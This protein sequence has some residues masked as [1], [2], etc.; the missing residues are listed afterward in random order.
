MSYELFHSDQ[1]S[2]LI[3]DEEKMISKIYGQFYLKQKTGIFCHINQLDL[4]SMG[5]EYFSLGR[6]STHHQQSTEENQGST[7][8]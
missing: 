8:F 5:E 7:S 6:L 3:Y 1:L 2:F 4:A